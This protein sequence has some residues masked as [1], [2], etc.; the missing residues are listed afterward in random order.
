MIK[1]SI[2]PNLI[3]PVQLI[4]WTLLRKINKLLINILLE[5]EI[6]LIFTLLMFLGE[7]LSG[8]IIYLYQKQF[9]S[10]KNEQTKFMFIAFYQSPNIL[11]KPDKKYKIFILLFFSAFFDFVQFITYSYAIPKYFKLSNSLRDRLCGIYAIFSALLFS[12]VLKFEIYK[13]QICSIII[14]GMGL[15]I[16]T[17]TEFFFQ[18]INIFLTYNEF[19]II[20]IILIIHYFFNS[21]LDIIEKYL[22]ELDYYNPF[23][24]LMWQGIFGFIISFLYCYKENSLNDIIIYYKN[25]SLNKFT[26]LMILFF[27]YMI[28]CGIRNV[29]RVITNKIYS[30]MTKALSD[31]VINPIYLIFEFALGY[32]FITDNKKNY[33]YFFINLIISI[34]TTICGCIHNEI[35]VLFFC[36]LE[37]QTHRQISYRADTLDNQISAAPDYFTE[38][39]IFDDNV[40]DD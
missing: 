29:F 5:F 26:I 17:I 34:I 31:Y 12:Y 14:I 25:N 19:L 32:D 21:A 36:G 4:I 16:V 7:I 20:L 33:G 28:L 24:A 6:S 23:E 38:Y 11:K 1:L 13:H 18:E 8:S 30:P 40:T 22:F 37:Y 9:I 27:I 3:Y 15:L 10:K 39:N 2:R 35:I